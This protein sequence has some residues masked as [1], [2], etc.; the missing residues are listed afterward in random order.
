MNEIPRLTASNPILS[1]SGVGQRQESQAYNLNGE[2]ISEAALILL[3]GPRAIQATWFP[4]ASLCDPGWS[5]S[6]DGN[7]CAH[8]RE[9]LQLTVP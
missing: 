4:G 6:S 8:P 2:T 9:Q 1:R 3:V 7:C 5:S